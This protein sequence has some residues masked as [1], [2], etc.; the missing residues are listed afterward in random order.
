LSIS[1]KTLAGSLSLEV[2]IDIMVEVK[3]LHSK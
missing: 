1:I 3:V 2:G